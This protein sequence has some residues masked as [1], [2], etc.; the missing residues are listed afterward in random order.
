MSDGGFE[1][2]AE[3]Q[4]NAPWQHYEQGSTPPATIS[5]NEAHSGTQSLYLGGPE[6][7]TSGGE[8]LAWQSVSVPNSARSASLSFW[9]LPYASSCDAQSGDGQYALIATEDASGNW[10]ALQNVMQTL[11]NA[12]GWQHIT[13]DVSLAIGK[14]VNVTFGV[15]QR[16][17]GC[18]TA[19]FIDDVSLTVSNTNPPS[20]TA[21]PTP[22]ATPRLPATPTATSAPAPGADQYQ[23]E[24]LDLVNGARSQQGLAPYT[25][26]AAESQGNGGCPGSYGHSVHMAQEGYISHDQFPQDICLSYRAAGEN[27]GMGSGSEDSAIRQIHNEMMAEGPGGGHYENIMSSTYATIGIGLYYSGGTLWLTEDFIG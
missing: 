27:V 1:R 20:G 25:F 21:T 23:Q 7:P 6:A 22:T 13:A 11:S 9:Y 3:G 16:S 12:R 10:L 19:M 2:Q 24:L 5:R 26:S 15:A 14:T 8:G 4:L 17:P 18:W